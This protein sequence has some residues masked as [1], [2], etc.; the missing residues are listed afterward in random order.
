MLLYVLSREEKVVLSHLWWCDDDG[1]CCEWVRFSPTIPP[2]TQLI[3]GF[4]VVDCRQ[5]SWTP[6]YLPVESK[7]L[8]FI[9]KLPEKGGDADVY[10]QSSMSTHAYILFITLFQISHHW[11]SISRR[12]WRK[13]TT[14]YA[15]WFVWIELISQI[16]PPVSGDNEVCFYPSLNNEFQLF[17]WRQF[18]S[19]MFDFDFHWP[20]CG[21]PVSNSAAV[22]IHWSEVIWFN[23]Q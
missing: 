13:L 21:R 1:W 17:V 16:S 8:I 7:L 5:A 3:M 11:W 14:K 4:L 15:P 9:S 23:F 18:I 19:L 12:W 6:S 20:V 10:H 2:P 22:Y